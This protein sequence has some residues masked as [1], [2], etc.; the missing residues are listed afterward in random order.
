M[1]DNTH[2][3]YSPSKLPRIMRCP[4][5]TTVNQ[6]TKSSSY[7]IEGTLCHEIVADHLEKQLYELN[8]NNPLFLSF[9]DGVRNELGEAIQQC[10]DYTF[11]IV[12]QYKFGTATLFIEAPVSLQGYTEALM[13]PDLADVY[14]TA[15]LI[16][17]V[18]SEKIVHVID[19]KFGKGVEVFPDSEQVFAYG[20]AAL[21]HI[22]LM[23]KYDKVYLHIGQP[24]LYSGEQF[25]VHET[26]PTELYSW[27]A[28]ELVPALQACN[29]TSPPFVPSLKACQWCVLKA[30]CAARYDLAQQTAQDVFRIHAELPKVKTP[31][32]LADFLGRARDLTAYISEIEGYVVK[33]LKSGGT[34]TGLKMV[35]GRS[36]RQWVDAKA[37]F[38]WAQK[39]VPDIEVFEEPK[40]VSP[41]KAEKLVKRKLASTDEFKALIHKPEGKHTLVNESDPRPAISY[42][43]ASDKFAAFKENV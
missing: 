25:K 43:S 20:A 38:Q 9:E 2:A 39:N 16:I 37:F 12:A 17:M 34:I 19:W 14:G 27:M 7:A 11:G 28:S 30:T 32:E 15:D 3:K 29:V 40:L 10:L 1:S 8:K 35:E 4:G 23:Q 13:C 31:E 24:R 42:E 6:D 33:T 21:K 41:A 18:P 22:N 5:S 36:I 26:T